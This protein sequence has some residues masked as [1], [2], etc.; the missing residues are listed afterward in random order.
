MDIEDAVRGRRAIR[1]FVEDAPD[2]DLIE[3]VIESAC[4]A[5]S[6]MD[7]QP[8]RFVVVTGRDLLAECSDRCK[9]TLL[10]MAPAGLPADSLLNMLR[11]PDFKVFYDAPVLVLVCAVEPGEMAVKDVC[12]AAQTLMLSAWGR[13]L[14]TCWIG[15]SEAWLNSPEAKEALG[16]AEGLRVVAPIILGRPRGVPPAPERRPARIDWVDALRRPA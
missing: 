1:S 13:G 2:R 11:R 10:D 15:L 8:W 5:P 4:W 3:S 12:L 16:L 14:G 7:R 6:G 9:A